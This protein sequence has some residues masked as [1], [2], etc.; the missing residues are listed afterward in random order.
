MTT[1]LLQTKFY[2]PPVRS[3]L[4][5]R[6]RLIE[7]LD[8]GLRLGHRLTLISAPAGFGKT[9]LLSEWASQRVSESAGG[10]S[11]AWLSLDEGDNDPARFWTYFIAAFQTIEADVGA[12]VLSA[13]QTPQPPPTESV[14]ITLINQIATIPA[15]FVLVLDD[16]HLITAQPIHDV[17]TSL[18]DHLPGNMHLV[19]ATRADPPLPVARLRGRGQLM[20]LRLTDLRFTPDEAASFLNQV[21]RLDLSAEDVAALEART[22]GWIAGL[23]MAAVSMRGQEDV[24]GFIRAFTGSDRYILD[25]LVEEVLQHQ[26][27]S[28]QTFL[29]QTAIL[30]RLTGPLCDT[31]VGEIGDWRAEIDD[32]HQ[33]PISNIQSQSIL[34]YLES[35][36]LF[37]LPLDNERRWYRYHRLFADLLRQRVQQARPDLVLTL[38]RRASHWYEQNGFVVEAVGHA[39]AAEDLERSAELIEQAAE[40]TLMRSEVATLLRWVDALPDELVRAR[41]TLCLFHAWALLLG[42]HPIDQVESRLQRVDEDAD[43]AGKAAPLRAFV[44]IF[45]GRLPR[46]GELS[47]EALEQLAEDDLFLRGVAIWLLAISDMMEG[48][49]AR[50]SQALDEI[51]RRSQEAGNVMIAA[52]TTCTLAEL[53]MT[54]GQ[55][56]RA[57]ATYRRA[58]ELATDAQGRRLPIAGMA[59]IGLG[60]LEREWNNLETAEQ[61]LTEGIEQIEQWGEI[62]AIDGY[63]FLAYV[64]QAQGDIAGAADA[65][66]KAQQLAVQ[67]DATEMDDVFAGAHQAHL[68]V[69]QG[70]LEPAQRWIEERKLTV[71]AA[72]AELE[73]RISNGLSG[74]SRHWRTVEYL[75]LARSLIAQKGHDK[76]LEILELL[77]KI[78]ERYGLHGRVIKSQVFKALTYQAQG[79][80]T[81]ALAALERALSLAEPE[82]YVRVFVDEGEPMATLLRHAAGRGIAVEYVSKLLAVLET[83]DER[84]MTKMP[85]SSSVLRPSSL[86][87]P[88]SE[89]ELEVLR[90]LT[91]HLSS[92][93]IARELYISVHT[94]RYHIK[95]IYS[96]LGVHCRADAVGRARELDLL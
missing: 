71:D 65:I 29:L 84:R 15:P 61:Y 33:Y 83:K 58:L 48:D 49:L 80:S 32:H 46:A 6:W 63:I 43:L 70:D 24:A 38:H 73:E 75:T 91:T 72:L 50:G 31:V 36:N 5:P 40:A 28:V 68:S 57:K 35:F 1:S 66:Q 96:K 37:I 78:A 17:L 30:D 8:E 21:M 27:E 82:G 60:E 77:I 90:L 69:I 59:L 42:G 74:Y 85:P 20:E 41:P 18:L 53:H 25:Y 89:R 34:E 76:A 14:L 93:E 4:V 55:L 87:E 81:Q 92:T 16:Y 39:L 44:A 9:T 64:K 7:R 67:F 2:V 62:G 52:M 22:E 51:A 95:S 94:V 54:R 79:D 10:W 88:L 47:R 26:P 86:V 11:V 45:Q 12:G 23:Q 19:I 56:G 13:L 3:N